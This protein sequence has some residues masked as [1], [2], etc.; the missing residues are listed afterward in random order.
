MTEIVRKR[1]R[2]SAASRFATTLALIFGLGMA[3]GA[4]ADEAAAKNRLKAMSDY[5]AA[6]KVMSLSFDTNLEIVTKDK[7]INRN[8]PWQVRARSL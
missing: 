6:Q 8:S 1:L 3:S 5:M 2:I 7:K 4:R